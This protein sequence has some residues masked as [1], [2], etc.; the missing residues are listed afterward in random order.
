MRVVHCVCS[1][2]G[3]HFFGEVGDVSSHWR[4]EFV[5]ELV[6]VFVD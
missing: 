3:V 5:G 2:L 4:S 1:G 6:E